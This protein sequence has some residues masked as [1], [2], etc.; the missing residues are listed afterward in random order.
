M[1][2]AFASASHKE[3]CITPPHATHCGPCKGLARRPAPAGTRSPGPSRCRLRIPID[4]TECSV[5]APVRSGGRVQRLAAGI[6]E[7]EQQFGGA[8]DQRVDHR[9]IGGERHLAEMRWRKCAWLRGVTPRSWRICAAARACARTK[10]SALAIA[11]GE[12][13]GA[14]AA[15]VRTRPAP[16]MAPDWRRPGEAARPPHALLGW[17]EAPAAAPFDSPAA[18]AGVRLAAAGQPP[19]PAAPARCPPPLPPPAAS[20]APAPACAWPSF[21]RAS[22]W[23]PGRGSVCVSRSRR[24][25]ARPRAGIPRR[26]RRRARSARRVAPHRRRRGAGR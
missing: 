2:A 19:P 22:C 18:R 17:T 8:A 14:D 25:S 15:A 26:A 3:A 24:G 1:R 20:S 16:A 13:G 6:V 12:G 11:S 10:A 9:R 21:P 23:R 7:Q 4:A 5:S